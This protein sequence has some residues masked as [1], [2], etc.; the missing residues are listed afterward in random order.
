M[1]LRFLGTAYTASTP[2]I[3]TSE[4]NVSGI[5]RG[6][7]VAF[8]SAHPKEMNAAVALRYRGQAYLR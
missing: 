1:Q 2:S 4:L 7:S 6:H 8:N 5:Y 3:E